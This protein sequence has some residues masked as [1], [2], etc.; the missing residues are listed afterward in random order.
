MK[1]VEGIDVDTTGGAEKELDFSSS[2]PPPISWSEDGQ[3]RLFGIDATAEVWAIALVYFVQGI[4]GI[5]RLAVSYYYKDS[6]HIGPAEMALVGS[7][8]ILPWVV[9]PLY[10]FISDGFPLFGYKRR[11]YLIL[12]GITGTMSWLGLAALATCTHAG[13][14][15]A[16]SLTTA[17]AVS[18]VTLSSLGLA[19]SDVLVDAIVV[20]KSRGGQGQAGALQSLC[21]SSSAVGGILS[22]Y[23]SG[24]L[25]QAFGPRFVFG[26]TALFPLITTA[27]A[28]LIAETPVSP[29]NE[30]REG[31]FKQIKQQGGLLFN[32]FKEKAILLPV[33]FLVLWQSTPT[34]GSALFYFETNELQFQPEFL[35]RL[36]LVS[37]L[38][39]LAGVVIYDQKLKKI[40]LRTLFKWTCLSGVVLGMS[41]LILVSHV[42]RQFGLPDTLFALGDD[43]ILTVLGQI[44]F[45]PVLVLGANICPPGVEASLYAA[46]MS[47]NN[48]SG[49]L[50]NI[51]GG[52]ATKTLG[53]TESNFDNLPLLIVLTNLS[54]LLP[55]P[56]LFLL[57]KQRTDADGN[58]VMADRKSVV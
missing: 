42:N 15:P 26:V 38:A 16:S 4:T 5:S 52:L 18:A 54:G 24:S 21:W 36:S 58:L 2:G 37:S 44:A 9:K 29:S 27:V 30:E 40:P 35:G 43:V 47:V 17:T 46:L 31:V 14:C 11:S 20:T 34:S 1:D 48:L 10:G 22:A 3:L 33:I 19:F 12:S 28:G 55:L 41:P 39:S 23:A 56:F 7:I 8:Q 25:V 13:A 6:L 53:V 32:S 51:M 57:P 45:M 49:G 50:G